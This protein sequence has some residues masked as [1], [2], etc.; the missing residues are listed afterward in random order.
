[1]GGDSIRD[2][3]ASRKARLHSPHPNGELHNG[4]DR[5]WEHTREKEES[6]VKKHLISLSTIF[7]V[8]LVVGSAASAAARDSGP[9]SVRVGTASIGGTY[10]AYGSAW[11]KL[12]G[13]ELSLQSTAQVTGGPLQNIPLVHMGDLEFGQAVM[14]DA[15]DGYNGEGWAEGRGTYDNIRAVFPMYPSYW[16]SWANAE[17]G[18]KSV[19]DVA[20]KRLIIGPVGGTPDI[21]AR[22]FL[23]LFRI[24]AGEL[25][26]AGYTDAN[27]MMRD[28]QADANFTTS[29]I[30][31]PAAIELQT[32]M[33]L[34]IFGIS[35]EYAD[36]YLNVAPLAKCTIP[37]GT[38]KNQPKALD[39]VCG[40]DLVVTN[41]NLPDD[42]VYQ[43]VKTVMENN[44]ALVAGHASAKN[45]L[46]KH[47]QYIGIPLHP[48]AARYYKEQGLEIPPAAQP[49]D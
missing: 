48:G 38:Y 9:R 34:N 2:R 1:M 7:A 25:I 8:T 20:G 3:P 30:P 12:V 5:L 47:V 36:K 22:K 49:V 43:V 10:H 42:F 28:G 29:G 31:H 37:A 15:Y 6:T 18:I 26:N 11:A 39:T 16:H 33:S 27:Q 13:E 14:V 45:T 44:K 21:Q 46:A 24:K 41:K 32:S 19:E 40:W 4:T 23:P 17:S 35:G